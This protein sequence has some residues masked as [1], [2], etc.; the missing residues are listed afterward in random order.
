MM[1]RAALFLLLSAGISCSREESE[2]LPEGIPIDPEVARILLRE[3]DGT[4]EPLLGYDEE[5]SR[6]PAEGA[7]VPVPKDEA[8]ALIVRLHP[9][10]KKKGYLIFRSEQHFGFDGKPDR[11]A[12]LKTT[13]PFEVLRVMGTNGINCDIDNAAVIAKM[14]EWTGRCGLTL[15]GAGLDWCEALFGRPPSDMTAFAQEVYEFC[16]DIV[17]QGTGSV[18]KL[19]EEMKASGSLYLW[20]D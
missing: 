5:G 18:R 20:W 16:P 2:A 17:D 9:E 11:V 8:R 19:A 13:D 1:R 15:I 3:T 12:V 14:R 6:V 7:T 10:L 4:M